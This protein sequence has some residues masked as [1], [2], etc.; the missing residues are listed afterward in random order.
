MGE[1]R[2]KITTRTAEAPT[3]KKNQ[4]TLRGAIAFHLSPDRP[5][6]DDLVTTVAPEY[7]SVK[8]SDGRFGARA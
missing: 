7:S 4:R 3:R 5:D 1:I 8:Q 2:R 6:S